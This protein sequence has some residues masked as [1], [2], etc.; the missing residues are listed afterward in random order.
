MIEYDSFVADYNN[1]NITTHEVRRLNRLNSRK[2]RK[3]REMAISNGDIP[4]HRHMNTTG[5]K[6]YFQKPDGNWT[7]QK[8]YAN[9]RT[10]NVGD[11]SDEETA[12]LVRDKCLSVNWEIEK[13]KPFIDEKKISRV[14]NYTVIN[15]YWFIQKT[16]KGKLETFLTAKK[17]KLTENQIKEIVEMFRQSNWDKNLADSICRQFDIY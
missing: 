11:F 12:K 6:F 3:M 9:G 16:V 10:I 4:E 8:R 15:G 13:I 7:V 5:A 2:Y 14:K 1:L 17:E